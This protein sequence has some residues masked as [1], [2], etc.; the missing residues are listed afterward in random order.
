M[1]YCSTGTVGSINHHNHHQRHANTPDEKNV[2]P[3]QLRVI[4][5]TLIS[6]QYRTVLYTMRKNVVPVPHSYSSLQY[7]K[8]DSQYR[9]V[10]CVPVLIGAW[11]CRFVVSPPASASRHRVGCLRNQTVPYCRLVVCKHAVFLRRSPT[12]RRNASFIQGQ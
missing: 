2:V 8:R 12:W 9:Y 5:I 11:R 7:R 3:F 4:F 6:V 10:Q 1:V